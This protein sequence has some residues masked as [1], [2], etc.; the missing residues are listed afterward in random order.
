MDSSETTPSAHT[1]LTAM[2]AIDAVEKL[3]KRGYV[4]QNYVRF[5]HGNPR[6]FYV[7]SHNRRKAKTLTIS[8]MISL[9]AGYT[10]WE[11]VNQA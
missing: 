11:G 3:K 9:A 10:T 5:S 8:A 1:A 2:N 7:V 4:V 6:D